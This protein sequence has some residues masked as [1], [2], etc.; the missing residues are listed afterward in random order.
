MEFDNF[1]ESLSYLY[2]AKDSDKLYV[3]A[4][5]GIIV[6]VKAYK[7]LPAGGKFEI[8]LFNSLAVLEVYEKS[9]PDKYEKVRQDFYDLIFD[10]AK[11]FQINLSPEQL[12]D[13]INSRLLLYS[14]ELYNIY[15][16]KNNI[17]GKIYSAFYKTPLASDPELSHDLLEIVKFNIGLTIMINWVHYH[18]NKI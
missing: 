3:I 8:V 14:N 2:D 1:L 11:E 4:V 13:F 18:T 16:R 9:H 15:A 12:E 10:G 6:L 7:N 5:G 17:P